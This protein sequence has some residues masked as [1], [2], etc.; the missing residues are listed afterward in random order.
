MT[1]FQVDQNLH[2]RDFAAEC[3]AGGSAKVWLFPKNLRHE[4]DEKILPILMARSNPLVTMDRDIAQDH[5]KSIP[6]KNPGIVVVGFAKGNAKSITIK[7]VKTILA[8]F[9][10]LFPRW[11]NTNLDG[12]ILEITPESVEVWHVHDNTVI[13]DVYL[14]FSADKWTDQ[15]ME[16]LDTNSRRSNKAIPE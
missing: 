12:S 14:P 9:K 8:Q 7:N 13:E 4:P 11:A 6:N 10:R 1:T 15:L 3:E 16:V 5:P 2:D